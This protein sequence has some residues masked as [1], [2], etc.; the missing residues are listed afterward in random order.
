MPKFKIGDKARVKYV[1]WGES[2]SWKP[3]AVVTIH[4]LYNGVDSSGDGFDCV[5]VCSNGQVAFPLFEQLEP[6]V[7]LGSWDTLEKELDWNPTKELVTN[8]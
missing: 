6:L 1:R 4:D 3:G 2:D 5:V 8:D 7:D